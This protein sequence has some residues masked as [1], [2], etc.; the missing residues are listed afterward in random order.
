MTLILLRL[1]LQ[2]NLLLEGI[3]EAKIMKVGEVTYLSE[4]PWH[5]IDINEVEHFLDAR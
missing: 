1:R 2:E 5:D 3:S 4:T